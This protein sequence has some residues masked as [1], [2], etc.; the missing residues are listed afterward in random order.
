MLKRRAI[1]LP[2]AGIVVAVHA[3][4][5]GL[6]WAGAQAW[7]PAW[8]L[9]I[10]A[11]AGGY[12][13]AWHGSLQHEIIH[14]HPTR[15]AR[16]NALLGSLPVGL[17]LPFGVYRDQHTAHHRSP[18]LTDPLDDP[19]SFY[20][21][22]DA[23]ASAGLARRLLL[24]AQTTALGRLVLGPPIAVAR[25][26]AQELRAIAAGNFAHGRAWAAHLAG[27]ALVVAWL[28]LVCHMPIARYVACFVYPG[29]ALT[30]LRSYAEHRPADVAAHRIGIVEAGAL[31]RL[32]YLNNNLHVV[33]HDA[34]GAPW[35][36][37][38]AMYAA[39]RA[40][41]LEANGGYVFGGYLAVLARY[42]IREKDSPVHPAR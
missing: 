11:A 21:T 15:W 42:G 2:T 4:W 10:L 40:E 14:G 13:V 31:A 6:T 5:L 34:P 3:A 28:E 30:L 18:T 23:W 26:L 27:V 22:R 17:W 35:Y 24:R 38:P 41:V 12:V 29:V 39:R 37:L 16:V 20:V 9:P 19:E 1:E 32:L 7:F 25:F 33:H 8:A 36:E